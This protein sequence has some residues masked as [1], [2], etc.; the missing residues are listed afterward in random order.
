MTDLSNVL[1]IPRSLRFFARK[2]FE[3][4]CLVTDS[5]GDCVYVTADTVGGRYQISRCDPSDFNMMPSAGVITS[6]PTTTTC[7]VQWLGELQGVVSGFTP[8]L[9]VLVGETGQLSQTPPDPP[10]GEV[11]Y[12]QTMGVA[13]ASDVVLLSPEILMVKRRGP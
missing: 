8:R 10:T 3:A 4:D 2:T 11:R 7:V 12:V 5:A 13:L 6:K 9:P 1:S